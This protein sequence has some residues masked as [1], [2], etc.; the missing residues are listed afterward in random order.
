M[1]RPICW[2]RSELDKFDTD[3]IIPV[4]LSAFASASSIG[5]RRPRAAIRAASK[6]VVACTKAALARCRATDRLAPD[7]GVG[8]ADP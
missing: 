6:Q 3:R 1:R 8:A 4:V 2:R 7:V 5:F